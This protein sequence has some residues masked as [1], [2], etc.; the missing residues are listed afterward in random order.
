MKS[1]K[2][3][4]SFGVAAL[5]AAYGCSVEVEETNGAGG[6]NASSSSTS[7]VVGPGPTTSVA[8]PQSS[9][10]GMLM[11]ESSSC[12]N[13]VALKAGSNQGL[14]FLLGEG[15]LAEPNDKD[16]FTFTA[17]KGDWINVGT[18]ANPDDDPMMVDTVVSVLS[19]D[20]KTVFAEVDDSF[21]RVST[22]TNFE[23]RVPADGTYCLQVQEFSAWNGMEPEGDP[24]FSYAVA[25]IPYDAANVKTLGGLDEDKEPNDTVSAPQTLVNVRTLQNGQ[26]ADFPYGVLDPKTDKDVFKVTTPAGAV[27]FNMNLAPSGTMNGNGSTGN[28]GLI[29]VY[30]GDGKNLLAQ[31]DYNDATAQF[32]S[33]GDYG[34]S[35]V[36][37]M[38]KTD[39]LI[40]INRKAGAEVGENDFYFNK[41]F[42]S[43][44]LN[45]QETDDTKNGSVGGAEAMMA[46]VNANDPTFTNRFIGGGIPAGDTDYWKF[47]AEANEKII[48]VCSAR[49][50][51]AGVE[52]F[53]VELLDSSEK[54]LQKESEKATQD[55]FWSDQ[56]D[57]ASMKA[58]PAGKKGTF[59]VKFTATK[60]IANGASLAF[61]SCGVHTQTP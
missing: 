15:V 49:R 52:D 33:G 41:L 11:D 58:V 13:A 8:G 17:K 22:D 19:A 6:G 18:E 60:S 61:Y 20:G 42:T 40:E 30:S 43:A 46:Q 50:S 7:T 27:G 5:F 12:A 32:T 36:P 38:E 48:V 29:N 25:V 45:P 34:F 51:G 56:G 57:T 31:L 53:T 28:I 3:L 1:F 4:G 21:P 16:F 35:S 44:E 9:S 26:I 54:S 14:S 37:V 23:F 59:Y 39:Y 47:D 2:I 10:S 24:N 55:I